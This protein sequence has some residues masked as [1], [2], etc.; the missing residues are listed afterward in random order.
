MRAMSAGELHRLLAG[1]AANAAPWVESAARYGISEALLRLGQMRLDGLGVA[2]DQPAALRCFTRAAKQGLPEA[3]NMVGRCYEN[4]W[5]A[6]TD[7]GLAAQWYRRAAD[8][9][10]D[11]GQYNY[12]NMLFDGR[13]APLDRPEARVWYR[14][15]AAQGHGRAMNLLARCYEEG[16]GGTRDRRAAYQWYQR[17]AETGY[18]RAQYNFATLLVAQG[19]LGEALGWFEKACEAATPETRRSMVSALSQQRDARLVELAR[20]VE[21]RRPAD[22]TPTRAGMGA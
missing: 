16:W 12:A 21:G 5:G 19:R 6:A 10:Y 3:M 17:S 15:A 18:F 2:Q 22:A 8:A 9:G 4:G 20:R 13:G 14:R 7:L 11:W 1:D